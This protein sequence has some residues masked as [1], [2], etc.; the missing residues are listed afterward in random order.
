MA[1]IHRDRQLLDWPAIAWP[2][3]WRQMLDADGLLGSWLRV[4]EFEEGDTLVVRAEIPDID[5]DKDV[6]VTTAD[7]MVHIHAHREEKSEHKDKKGYR[8]EFRYGDFD[9]QIALPDGA[10]PADV[11]ARYADG[12]LEVRT[13]CPAAPEQE[14]TRITVSHT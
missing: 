6:E 7:G 1:L 10:S 4:E 3:R 5:P 2:E 8:S 14:P 12:I 13:P 11:T 9:R